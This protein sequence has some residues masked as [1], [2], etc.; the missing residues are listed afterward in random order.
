MGEARAAPMRIGLHLAGAAAGDLAGASVAAVGDVNGDG[1]SDVAVGSYQAAVDGHPRVGRVWVVFRKRG[2]RTVDLAHLRGRGF[3]VDGPSSDSGFGEAIIPVGDVNGDRRADLAI[4]APDAAFRNR[5]GA[6]AVFVV[7]GS[8]STA[9]VRVGHLGRRGIVIGGDRGDGFYGSGSHIGASLALLGEFNGDDRSDLAI[10]SQCNVSPDFAC[11]FVVYGG[12]PQA[13]L[14][15]AELGSRG[16]TISRGES[17]VAPFDLQVAAAGDVNGDGLGDL[18]L[19]EGSEPS[20]FGA[21][22]RVARV[23]FGRSAGGRLSLDTMGDGGFAI[24][25][26]A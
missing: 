8:R 20:R 9:R 21:N 11:A 12:A 4:G 3:V 7:F 13:T 16:L 18:L 1:V 6:G 23:V 15:L 19:G 25:S 5:L 24:V 17:R 22:Q 10:G 14:D 26:N 2:R